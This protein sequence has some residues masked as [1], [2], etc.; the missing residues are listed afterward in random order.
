MSTGI[1]GLF[2]TIFGTQSIP[3]TQLNS[4]VYENIWGTRSSGPVQGDAGA[5]I[6]SSSRPA[7]AQI[8]S[9]SRPAGAAEDAQ[10]NSSSR[11]ADTVLDAQ[12]NSS[13]RPNGA[14]ED[15][16]INSSSRSNGARE[17]VQINSSSTRVNI[18]PQHSLATRAGSEA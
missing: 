10:I 3:Q 7:G 6:G 15:V 8:D 9:S 5:Q 11:P 2:A 17:G 13:S 18:N 1:G 4:M 14:R 12:I 16:Q